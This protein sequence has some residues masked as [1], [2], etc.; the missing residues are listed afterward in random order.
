MGTAK[1][2]IFR[3]AHHP[4]PCLDFGQTVPEGVA[5]LA[6]V[7][8]LLWSQGIG[9]PPAIGMQIQKKDLAT[10]CGMGRLSRT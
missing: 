8:S 7:L 1:M 3:L 10:C 2:Q 9:T 6:I 4:K 5:A